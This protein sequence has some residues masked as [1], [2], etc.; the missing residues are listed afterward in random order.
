VGRSTG[1]GSEADTYAVGENLFLRKNQEVTH[2]CLS[3]SGGSWIQKTGSVKAGFL[4]SK[5]SDI[6]KE[7]VYS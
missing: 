7:N 4:F 1:K 2:A 6:L 5:I 3:A